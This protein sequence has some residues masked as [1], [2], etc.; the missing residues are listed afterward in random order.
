LSWRR[1]SVSHYRRTGQ[2]GTAPEVSTTSWKTC[3]LRRLARSSASRR[4]GRRRGCSPTV[5]R[6]AGRRCVRHRISGARKRRQRALDRD[7]WPD[8]IREL[9]ARLVYGVALDVTDR[10]RIENALERRVE[11]RTRELEEAN[12]ELRSQITQREIAET[13]S[14]SGALP[15]AY[16][17]H[18]GSLLELTGTDP[19]I[20]CGQH[21]QRHKSPSSS[22][23]RPTQQSRSLMSLRWCESPS[24]A[25]R[26]A[27]L[28]AD[29]APPAIIGCPHHHI[30][31]P[32]TGQRLARAHSQVYAVM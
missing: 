29:Q 7:A 8:A 32:A 21:C 2:S 12:K 24:N 23:K 27:A 28:L 10:K 13:R 1:R 4:S 19:A 30:R 18:N 5:Y 26:I 16:P 25:A 9:Q 20:I 3:G 15:H 14:N 17:P 22:V 31:V 11:A 6:P